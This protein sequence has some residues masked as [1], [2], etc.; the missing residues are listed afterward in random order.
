MR[1]EICGQFATHGLDNSVIL[2]HVPLQS[3]IVPS[4]VIVMNAEEIVWVFDWVDGNCI[5]KFLGVP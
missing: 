1:H 5:V 2:N 4:F 3:N